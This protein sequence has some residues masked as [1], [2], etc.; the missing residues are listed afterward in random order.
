MND[1]PFKILGIE[2]IGIAVT[3]LTTVNEIFGNVLGLNLSKRESVEDQGVITD[4]YPTQSAKLEFVKAITEDSPIA[5]F[6]NKKGEGMHHIALQVD[7]LQK[8]LDY[9]STKG[10]QLIDTQPRIGAEGFKIAFIH[11]KSTAGILVEL[12]E[13][14]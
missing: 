2:H 4:I 14:G 12:C 13:K 1:L 6:I 8:A 5:K 11:P 7:H 9:L 10:V 3:D